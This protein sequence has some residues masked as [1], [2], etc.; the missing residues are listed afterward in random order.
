MVFIIVVFAVSLVVIFKLV[1]DTCNSISEFFSWV[2][3]S[4]IMALFV[5]GIAGV[6]SSVCFLIFPRHVIEVSHT[7]IVALSNTSQVEGQFFLGSG[8]IGETQY[9]YY[10][11]EDEKGFV[12]MRNMEAGNRIWIKEE[13]RVDGYIA[14]YGC[15]FEN[16]DYV[17]KY[18]FIGD[19]V[20]I[21][22]TEIV[23]P[24]G[25]IYKGFMVQLPGVESS[26]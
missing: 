17:S 1:A 12:S 9:Y 14:E 20:E 26:N 4:V 5:T 10:M 24:K 6:L 7:P 18:W 22:R 19:S 8:S 23:V 3:V 25:S 16:P 13:D 11:V 2:V 15:R 21:L